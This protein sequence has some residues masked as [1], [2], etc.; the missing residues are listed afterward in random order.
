M[1]FWPGWLRTELSLL[2][3]DPSIQKSSG[4][5]IPHSHGIFSWAPSYAEI[6]ISGNWGYTTGNYEHRAKTLKDAVD[7]AGQY[8]TV[9]QKNVKGEWK[10]LVD[11]GNKHAAVPPQ[12][13]CHDYF[14]R[15]IQSHRI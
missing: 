5:P 10:Y 1:V 6:S 8:T 13:S 9:W 7:D 15:K 12:K 11:I 4:H 2:K 14:G 3:K